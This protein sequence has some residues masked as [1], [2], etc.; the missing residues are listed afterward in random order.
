MKKMTPRVKVTGVLVR[1]FKYPIR[2]LISNR[3]ME[4]ASE[5][6]VTFKHVII[7]LL[8]EITVAEEAEDEAG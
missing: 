2:T 4:I 7:P 8:S 6:T 1:P 3:I 5:C